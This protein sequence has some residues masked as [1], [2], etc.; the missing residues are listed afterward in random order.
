[1]SSMWKRL[2]KTQLDFKLKKNFYC[3]IKI[4]VLSLF[5]CKEQQ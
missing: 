4:R 5:A 2:E 3:G 1:M